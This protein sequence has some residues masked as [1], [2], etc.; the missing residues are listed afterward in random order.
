M[1]NY[2]EYMGYVPNIGAPKYIKQML[3]Y[4]KG[5]AGSNTVI[6]GDFTTPLSTMVR[7]SGQKINKETLDLNWTLD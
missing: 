7:S 4:L 2:K 5:E 6:A 1:K 3:T